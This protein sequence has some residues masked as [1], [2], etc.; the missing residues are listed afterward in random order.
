MGVILFEMIPLPD[1]VEGR[2]RALQGKAR[3][4]ELGAQ[5]E[6]L[7]NKI[8]SRLKIRLIPDIPD[9]VLPPGHGHAAAAHRLAALLAASHQPLAPLLALATLAARGHLP[10]ADP[11]PAQAHPGETPLGAGGQE[12]QGNQADGG[13]HRLSQAPVVPAQGSSYPA[14]S[15]RRYC[16][17]GHPRCDQPQGFSPGLP[18][19]RH[20]LHHLLTHLH[21]MAVVSRG[22]LAQRQVHPH[23]DP[24]HLYLQDPAG[25]VRT[26]AP[27]RVGEGAECQLRD[28]RLV[29]QPDQLWHGRGR[30]GLSRRQVRVREYR[31]SP[32]GAARGDVAPGTDPCSSGAAHA[33]PATKP[34]SARRWRSTTS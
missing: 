21:R 20:R 16:R 10:D 15:H 23:Q 5:R 6:N 8:L 1:D 17:V 11:Y 29:G 12:T 33:R 22:E 3:A 14:R 26:A 9:R 31:Q 30:D 4:G 27:G 13:R 24:H 19:V 2:I 18:G 25:L 32:Q 28:P 7:R 34:R